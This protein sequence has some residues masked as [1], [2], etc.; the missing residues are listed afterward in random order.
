MAGTTSGGRK[1]AKT[2]IKRHG[3]DFY[4]KIGHLGGKNGTTGGFY[5]DPERAR[6]AGSKGGQRSR[7]GWA[8]FKED[9][10]HLYYMNRETGKVEKVEK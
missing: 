4:A 5:A 9:K 8:L 6:A 10:T 2:N 3:K 1:A 7:R